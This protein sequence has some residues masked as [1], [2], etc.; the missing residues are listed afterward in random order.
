M[1]H[2]RPSLIGKFL[3]ETPYAL[4]GVSLPRNYDTLSYDEQKLFFPS[5][6]DV[7]RWKEQRYNDDIRKP[8]T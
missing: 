7:S 1:F 4:K 8:F 5:S 3:F 2:I 6:G